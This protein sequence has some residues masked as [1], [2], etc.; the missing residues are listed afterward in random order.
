MTDMDTLAQDA[1]TAFEE[2]KGLHPIAGI[3]ALGQIVWDL[4]EAVSGCTNMGD[5][6]AEIEAWATIFENPTLLAKTVSK[7]WLFHGEEIKQDIAQEEADWAAAQYFEAGQDT[8]DILVALV[9]PVE[10]IETE[11]VEAKYVPLFGI[12]A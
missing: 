9:G 3:E 11:V 8:A 4:P 10:P 7:H 6:I 1:E 12:R 2:L 5:D